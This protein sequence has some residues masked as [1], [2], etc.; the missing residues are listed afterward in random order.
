MLLLSGLNSSCGDKST[1]STNTGRCRISCLVS[2]NTF[3]NLLLYKGS[4]GNYDICGVIRCMV[5][6]VI[7][8]IRCVQLLAERQGNTA[9][10]G[11]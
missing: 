5:F 7:V 3:G 8:N 10:D 9:N 4:V 11:A 2:D 6:F 1:F